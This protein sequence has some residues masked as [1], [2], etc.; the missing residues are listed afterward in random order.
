MVLYASGDLLERR[1]DLAAARVWAGGR[2]LTV[3]DS[4]E[5]DLVRWLAWNRE[6][7]KAALGVIAAG[8]ADAL[9]IPEATEAAL[10]ESD[11]AWLTLT[12]REIGCRLETVP[13]SSVGLAS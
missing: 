4:F 1:E 8:R 10:T 6:P 13:R 12:L 7:L 2:G 5:D 3:V 11:R 9:G